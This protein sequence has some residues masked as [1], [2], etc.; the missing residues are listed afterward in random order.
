MIKTLSTVLLLFCFCAA[1]SF[2]N[3]V[4]GQ[5][6]AAKLP[7]TMEGQIAATMPKWTK[8]GRLLIGI[9]PPA[10]MSS[11]T[12]A[13]ESSLDPA[14]GP[15]LSTPYKVAEANGYMTQWF[16]S[17]LAV[18]PSTMTV[19]NTDKSLFSLPLDTFAPVKPAP[20]LLE[21][22]TSDQLNQMATGG[23][24]MA[25]LT[26]DQQALFKALL[27]TPFRVVSTSTAEP[28]GLAPPKAWADMSPEER[29][30]WSDKIA[31][32]SSAYNLAATTISDDTVLKDVRLH[33]YLNV[34][35]LIPDLGASAYPISILDTGAFSSGD[36]KMMAGESVS[37]GYAYNGYGI[38]AQQKNLS[39]LL[40]EQEPNA[41]KRGDFDWQNPTLKV[42]VSIAGVKSVSDLVSN[43]AK[44]TN[45]E[46]YADAS[47][48][49]QPLFEYGDTSGA[50]TAADLLRALALCVSGTWRQVGPAY[51]LTNDELGLGARQQFLTNV[52]ANWT[53]RLNEANKDLV[54]H[55]RDIGWPSNIYPPIGDNAE[56]PGSQLSAMLASGD[57]NKGDAQ[58]MDL[59]ESVKTV[60]SKC[61]KDRENQLDV[62]TAASI[63]QAWND[64]NPGSK[65]EVYVDLELA[66]E[67]PSTGIMS[68]GEYDLDNPAGDIV[69]SQDV[70][71]KIAMPESTRGVICAPKTPDEAR[72]TVD[73]LP[74][75]G[76]NAL[77]LDVFCN[78]RTY[79]KSAVVPPENDAAGD[80]LNSA[81]S[82]AALKHLAVYAVV[83]T[84]AWRKD[85]NTAQP[86]PWP[87]T[88]D[89]DRDIFGEPSEVG[90][91]RQI[92]QEAVYNETPFQTDASLKGTASYG[93]V[94]PLDPKVLQTLPVLAAELAKIPGLSG[95]IF[96]DTDPPGYDGTPDYLGLK[97]ELGYTLA[98]RLAFLRDKH[99]D[100]I[101]VGIDNKFGIGGLPVQRTQFAIPGFGVF[102]DDGTDPWS[103]FRK[104]GDR[105][106][107][108]ECFTAATTANPFLPIL[109]REQPQNLSIRSWTKADE[110][111][112]PAT[113]T[114]AALQNNG[115]NRRTILLVPVELYRQLGRAATLPETV[116]A[117]QQ[118]YH[119]GRDGGIAFDLVDAGVSEDVPTMLTALSP[120][121]A[122]PT[123]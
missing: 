2:T 36:D 41:P 123:Q 51:V 68:F 113:A 9:S 80:V 38:E 45:L 64:L 49:K 102:M 43:I 84:L 62:K 29:T 101:D 73:M 93:W 74:N 95:I 117:L 118:E 26:T 39:S 115:L 18:A 12:L 25:D 100:P 90:E 54:K 61:L 4:W 27:P 91:Q 58:W 6:T 121:L 40:T 103:A 11:V 44:A 59:P 57:S 110:V 65:V 31:Q 17:V 21:S 77:F 81:L 63:E 70:A 37:G 83:D 88:F 1:K 107:L 87:P 22:L 42:Q 50:Y 75:L 106:L 114:T 94:S 97:P 119:V 92:K 108:S 24:G 69:V 60:I 122:A 85:I 79:F 99:V 13:N 71:Q 10:T 53:N 32:L 89:E 15:D 23:L 96:Q 104:D 82:E 47:Y 3:P 5:G 72:K 116:D 8:P 98:N 56:L 86:A 111:V 48:E 120:Y 35:Y 34:K 105:A 109:M 67:L 28:S 52:V 16:G 78:G 19:L 46:L 20:F 30:D 33:A 66:L 14:N 112:E 76:L 55:L 7:Q